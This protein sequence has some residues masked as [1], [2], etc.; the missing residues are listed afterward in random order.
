MKSRHYR[1]YDVFTDK[2][3]AGNP[4]AV[5]FDADGL[6]KA[7]MQRIARE[8]NLSETVFVKPAENSIH[9]AR[10]GIF[11][12]AHELPFAGHPTVGAAIA[13]A[14]RA[15]EEGRDERTSILVLEENVGPVRCVVSAG[16]GVAFAEFDLPRLPQEI[17][18]NAAPE[19][20]AAALGLAHHEIGFENHTISAWSAGVPYVCVPVADLGVAAKARAN[21]DMWRGLA[22]IEDG[23][24]GDPYVYCRE[25]VNHDCSFHARM[26]APLSG[27]IEDPATG[28][29]A[30]AFAG[31]IMRFDEPVDGP[32]RFWIEQ[33][34]E[35]GRP[36]RIR[37]E[38]DV[39]GGGIETGRI[40]GHA[41][42]VAEGQFFA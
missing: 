5:V 41:V 12:P 15:R 28:S 30:A 7:G 42:M 14:E 22:P 39:E 20:V 40:G 29:A 2:V 19:A 11:T 37:L 23:V 33:G 16:N 17:P 35:M 21:A 36:S 25:T 13:L 24:W 38:L 34:M 27:I 31:A 32:N 1:V 4:L 10:L 18:V 9:T 8:F 3:L 26:F 6:D